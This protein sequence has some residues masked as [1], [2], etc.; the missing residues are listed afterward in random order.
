MRKLAAKSDMLIENFK[1]GGLPKFGL[2][3]ASLAPS[4]PRLIYCSVTGFGQT[5]PDAARAGYDLMAQGIGG[6][7]ALTGTAD[8]EPTR[9]G[10]PVSD[11]F[12]GVYSVIGILA[13]LQ[14]R[15]RTGKGGYVDTA[16]V[17]S[18]VGVLA[19]QAMNYLASGEV[20]KR[21]GNA[22]PN[23]VPYQVFPGRRRAHHHRDRQRLAVR[24]AV[25]GAGRAGACEE[26][27]LSRQQGP[28]E[29]PPAA[30]RAPLGT[31]EED[32]SATIC[33]TSSKR[34]ACRPARSTI[35]IR[36]ST[37]RRSSIAAC[38]SIPKSDAA[39]AGSIP[40]VRTPIMLD[41]EPMAAEH[42]AP[43][44]GAAYGGDF[45][46]DRGV[47]SPSSRGAASGPGMDG[48]KRAIAF[49]LRGYGALS[50]ARRSDGSSYTFTN[51]LGAAR[52][53]RIP[54]AATMVRFSAIGLVVLLDVV[55]IVVIVHHQ[56]VRLREALLGQVGQRSRAAPAARRC[57][58]GSARPD[59]PAAAAA[60]LRA[61]GNRSRPHAAAAPPAR[62]AAPSRHQSGSSSA[63][64]ALESSGSRIG[65]SLLRSRASQSAKPGAGESV[66]KVERRGNSRETSS[67][68]CLIRKLPKLTPRKP[69][70]AVGDRIEHGRVR[71]ARARACCRPCRGSARSRAG[72][73]R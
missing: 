67:T 71:R 6:F 58:D 34:S 70:L 55:E 14:R 60:A 72:C 40:G 66:T 7:M 15:E 53:L 64:S 49:E 11:I 65:L 17:D 61:A 73:R 43:R 44:L 62:S 38:R 2:D 30:D 68:T 32:S 18:T 20:P 22:H 69:A 59:R 23:I 12:T 37:T 26:S 28:A 9:A 54:L 19:N 57:R 10:V 56:A 25:R 46:R 27:R 13:A 45:A 29:E 36:C 16:L 63:P 39:K 33:S 50:R 51:S 52:S 48:R 21:I 47:D 5:G 41:G 24:Q 42:P 8:G 31:D 3:Y 1:V 4:C 35:S